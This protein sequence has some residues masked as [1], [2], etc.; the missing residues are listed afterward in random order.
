MIVLRIYYY[1]FLITNVIIITIAKVTPNTD[2]S[3]AAQTGLIHWP[4][5]G[6]SN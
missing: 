5:I 2:S 1:S 3:A 6:V 4:Q